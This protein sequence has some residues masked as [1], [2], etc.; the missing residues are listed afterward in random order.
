MRGAKRDMEIIL[1]V[2]PKE[3]LL[4]SQQFGHFGTK[5]CPLHFESALG[6]FYLFYSKRGTKRYMKIF[7][8]IP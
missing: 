4:Y 5:W 2:F 8:F 3:N 6:F 7:L 1:M